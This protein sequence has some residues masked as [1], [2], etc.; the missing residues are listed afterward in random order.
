MKVSKRIAAIMIALVA[1]IAVAGTSIPV[2][3]AA[4]APKKMTLKTTSKTIDIKGKATIS[5]KS[6]SPKGA[7]TAVKYATNNK[8][9]ATVSSKGVVTGK[10][11]GKA[12]ITVTSKKNKTL[13]KK[14]KITVKQLKPTSVS[15]TSKVSMKVGDKKTLTATVKPAGV[16]CPVTWTSS[17]KT[18]ATV[19]KNGKVTAK[20][21]GTA[22]ITV[23]TKE[24]NKKGKY[25]TKKCTVTV[26]A[27]EVKV[28]SLTFAD[29][30]KSLVGLGTTYT[31]KLTV[32]PSNATNK[33]VAYA[34]SDKTVA[35]VDA[36][37]KVTT[38]KAGE[39]TI[40]ATAADGS[41]K[42]AS[43][44]LTVIARE[45]DP[46]IDWQYVSCDD[47]LNNK[48]DY[49][50]IDL[51]PTKD[52]KESIGDYGYDQ[53]HIEGS[54]WVPAWPVGTKEDEDLLRSSYVLEQLKDNAKDVVFV[55]RSGAGGAKGAIS[56]L[57]DAGI[58][59]SRMYILRDGASGTTGLFSDAHKGQLVTGT[60]E[61]TGDYIISAADL[62]AK[63]AANE[64]LTLVD[65]RGI[66]AKTETAEG[67]VTISWPSISNMPGAG[68][69]GHA[70]PL[71]A[72]SIS[73]KLGEA[74]LGINDQIILFSSDYA[75]SGW[76]DDGRIAW[77]LLQC[78]YTN[79]KMV[80]GGLPAMKAAGIKTQ[81]GPAK[82]TAKT[83]TVT[84][85]DTTTHD[86][87]T[88]KLLAD[89]D[90]YTIIDVRANA[91][92]E[93]AVLYGE[94]SG[95]HIKGAVHIRFT[96][97]FKY[98]GTLKSADELKAMFEAAGITTDKKVVTYCTGGIRSAYMQLVLQ[99]LGYTESYNYAESAYRW[100]NTADAK[101]AQYWND[102][103][104]INEI[105]FE[106]A[107]IMIDVNGL[108]LTSKGATALKNP[109]KSKSGAGSVAQVTY[110]SSDEKV[111]K[112]SA[113]GKVITADYGEATITATSKT[114]SKVSYKVTVTD[115][116][117]EAITWQYK[118]GSEAIEG[119]SKGEMT[120]L[121]IRLKDDFS[122][123]HIAG[124]LW[125]P[126]WPVDTKT[127]EDT[128][129]KAVNDELKAG[130]QPVV[131]VCR[132]GM[133][134]AKRAISLLKEEGIPE[135]RLYIL[136]GGGNAL[137]T[138]HADKLEKGLI[139]FENAEVTLNKDGV[140]LSSS[141]AVL[142]ENKLLPVT[143]G[144]DV[145][146]V[147]YT[148]SDEKVAVV[149]DAGVVTTAGYGEAVITAT[150]GS[151]DTAS[152][153]VIVKDRMNDPISWQSVSAGD[154]IKG[155]AD[156]TWTIIDTRPESLPQ[157]EGSAIADAGYN[158]G[159][160]KGSLWVKSWPVNTKENRCG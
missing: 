28:T 62:K 34:S 97:L 160:I 9:V 42:K 146:G 103:K 84:S 93:G 156:G 81:T 88:E 69:A 143:A 22:T 6:V 140:I 142:A 13:K 18:V 74:G 90:Q 155:A 115:R 151:G 86:I 57:K 71:D 33:K 23:K 41:G 51:R 82:A 138:D 100:S 135:S 63:I 46:S 95:G 1:V 76:G 149:T 136:T 130:E 145:S 8:K 39:T 66:D 137:M 32:A 14:V 60:E 80:N 147:T 121:D 112:V 118:T 16:Y 114:G 64:T 132:A 15:L 108:P 98:D 29:K 31:N 124:S 131:V 79:V 117:N 141:G 45:N 65:T 122:V 78:G 91:E 19:D 83:V 27:K 139:K 72:A 56:V 119:A 68:K 123:G 37:G 58:D 159:H 153:K 127:A 110:V 134:G 105:E 157:K 49:I 10:K 75:T 102:E 25:I 152:Y 154:A 26:T 129:R 40:T 133:A 101:T 128:V 77:Q 109:V 4:K 30:T 7:S 12:T 43:Y 120:V 5:V 47:V 24:K 2:E 106:K 73:K 144:I 53:G 17:N 150:T 111:A 126:S 94:A 158:V 59:P 148:T 87:T 52:Q 113:S 44:K 48:E 89:F 85:V 99:M 104:T 70:R 3:A 35:T 96:D 54:V 107:E 20:K 21:A 61:F 125:A 116:Q 11:A 92:Y 67:A 50:I 38:V 36:S 55:C